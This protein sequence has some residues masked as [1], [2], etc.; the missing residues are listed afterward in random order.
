MKTDRKHLNI[1]VMVL[2]IQM[3]SEV[4]ALL[5]GIKSC[6][7]LRNASQRIGT[8]VLKEKLEYCSTRPPGRRRRKCTKSPNMLVT[9][10]VIVRGG[11]SVLK[12]N[13]NNTG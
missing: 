2:A 5:N 7:V 3:S 12:S 1:D 4:L 11:T 10:I 13:V 8:Q 6:A 9:K